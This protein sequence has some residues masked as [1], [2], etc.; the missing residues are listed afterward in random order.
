MKLNEQDIKFI[1]KT[2]KTAKII[3]I[4]SVI[5]EPERIRAIDEERSVF[6][7]HKQDIPNLTFDSIGINRTDLLL[8]RLEIAR[9]GS[10]FYGECKIDESS[11]YVRKLTFGSKGTKVD[12]LCANP[13]SIKAPKNINDQNAFKFKID[14]DAINMMQKGLA[15][16]GSENVTFIYNDKVFFE[17]VDINNDVFSYDISDHCECIGEEEKFAFKFPAKKLLS[18]LKNYSDEQIWITE[19]GIMNIKVNDIDVFILQRR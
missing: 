10:N 16:M 11:G 18:L 12:Y 3:G 2:T 13:S 4:D 8:S 1:E 6:I 7:L 9:E 19:Q 17:M 14:S 15:A 5:I